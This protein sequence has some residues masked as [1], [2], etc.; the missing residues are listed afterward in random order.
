MRPSGRALLLILLVCAACT[1]MGLVDAVIQPGYAAKS[2]VKLLLFLALPL[3]YAWFVPGTELLRLF[4]PQRRSLL[5]ALLTG[6]AVF[7]LILGAY[8][9]LRD[10]MDFSGLTRSLTASTGVDRA[11]FPLVALYISFVNS[12]LE[13][14]FFR[15]FAFLTLAKCTSPRTACCFSAGAFALYHV[16]MMVGWFP[17]PVQILAVTGLLAGGLFF[18]RCAACSGGLLLPWLIHMCANFAINTVGLLLFAAP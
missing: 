8:F 13:E 11:S 5:P 10:H 17:L 14:F 7:C 2:A 6:A 4:C 3:L 15:G 12:L 1:A 9:L 16:A 18:N